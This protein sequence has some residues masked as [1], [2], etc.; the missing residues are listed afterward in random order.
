[1]KTIKEIVYDIFYEEK[2]V[3]NIKLL[4]LPRYYNLNDFLDEI[5]NIN[6]LNNIE[7]NTNTT[8]IA[9]TLEGYRTSILKGFHTHYLYDIIDFTDTFYYIKGLKTSINYRVILESCD[10]VSG[11]LVERLFET[12]SPYATLYAIYDS[13][14]PKRYRSENDIFISLNSDNSHYV[15]KIKGD[16]EVRNPNIFNFL[17]KI[18]TR[19]K[20]LDTILENGFSNPCID[21]KEI[22]V[23]KLSEILDLNIPIITPHISLIKD[24]NNEI[25]EYVN[26]NG[27]NIEKTYL[28]KNNEWL[29]THGPSECYCVEDQKIYCLPIGFRFRCKRSIVNNDGVCEVYFDLER[30]DGSIKECSINCAIP[31][32]EFLNTGEITRLHTPGTFKVYYGYVIP[33]FTITDSFYDEAIVIFDSTIGMTKEDLYTCILPIRKK[34]TLYYSEKKMIINSI[35]Y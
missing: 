35:H 8:F 33:S 34:F 17:N 1:M 14:I 27:N 12:L 6:K 16:K 10:M 4:N 32:F 19:N 2:N 15:E 18:R 11:D 26:I 20:R 9:T 7:D 3:G 25:R 23:I 21:I 24:L 31:Y 5:I 28:P 13:F 30:P 22:D 29:I